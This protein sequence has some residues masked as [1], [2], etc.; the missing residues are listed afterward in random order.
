MLEQIGIM[1][2]NGILSFKGIF[3]N[4]LQLLEGGYF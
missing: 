4:G 2:L 3:D 1:K